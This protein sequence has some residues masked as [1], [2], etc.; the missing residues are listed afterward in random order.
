MGFET[1]EQLKKNGGHIS[2][3]GALQREEKIE[4]TKEQRRFCYA[5]KPGCRIRGWH[6][7]RPNRATQTPRTL[8][9][10]TA[11]LGRGCALA[12]GTFVR[13]GN[14]RCGLRI[15]FFFFRFGWQK[16]TKVECG[17]A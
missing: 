15:S 12:L 17:T 9:A 3:L 5:K 10:T 14:Y 13:G 16:T 1:D 6:I 2:L 4:E 7:R 11:V 8:H